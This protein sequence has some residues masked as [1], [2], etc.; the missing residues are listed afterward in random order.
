MSRTLPKCAVLTCTNTADPRWYVSDVKGYSVMICDGHAGIPRPEE[1]APRP[2]DLSTKEIA[3]RIVRGDYVNFDEEER[4]ARE[5]IELSNARAREI[6]IDAPETAYAHRLSPEELAEE[7]KDMSPEDREYRRVENAT[8]PLFDMWLRFL[9]A[10]ADRAIDRLDISD[11]D[12]EAS[13]KQ[14]EGHAPMGDAFAV[15]LRR[16]PDRRRMR[17]L[18]HMVDAVWTT[19]GTREP[20]SFPEVRDRYA[21]LPKGDA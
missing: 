17:Q 5:L 7:T 21:K 10:F 4:V 8:S 2:T 13:A 18:M 9:D 16:I 6:V 15:V 1:V 20:M 14:M 12:A 11:E 19:S 3:E